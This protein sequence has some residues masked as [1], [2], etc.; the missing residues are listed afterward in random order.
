VFL[1]KIILLIFKKLIMKR[2]L[3]LSLILAFVMSGYA[4]KGSLIPK[5]L[6]NVSKQAV[7]EPRIH[8]LGALENT[9]NPTVNNSAAAKSQEQ[10]GTTWY[11]L[12]S[13]QAVGNRL[14]LFNDG[15]LGAVWMMGFAG[16]EPWSDRGTGYN[17]FD[18]AAWG[19]DP[20]SRI[21]NVKTG[22][23][24]IAPYGENG[25]I[26]V[27][28]TGAA[29][30]LFFNKRDNKGTG[31]WE[32]FFLA[33]PDA[34]NVLVW[35]RMITSGVNNEV[36]QIICPGGNAVPYQGQTPALLYSRSEDG[37]ATWTPLHEVLPGTGPDFYLGINADEYVWAN[38]VGDIIAFLVT[39][40]GHDWFAMKSLDGGSTWEKIMI[41]EHPYPFFDANT[42]LTTDTLW[43]PD[44][45]GDIA[46]DS[47]GKI[48][49]VC[50]LTRIAR[51]ETTPA[52][53]VNYW[54]YTDGVAYWNEDMDPF[55]YPTEPHDALDAWDVLTED[56]N[57]IGWMQDT[58]G[59]GEIEL[60]DGIM[61]YRSLSLTT[62]TNIAIAPDNSIYVVWSGTSEGYIY[63]SNEYNN[64][65]IWM[66]TNH[67]G[68]WG[69]F[70][71]LNTDL[72]QIFDE[73]IYPVLSKNIDDKVHLIYNVDE[74][75]GL[76]LD[77]DHPF[78]ENRMLYY[79]EFL[80]GIENNESNSSGLEVKQNFPNPASSISYI[81]VNT[82][83]STNLNLKIT[84][85]TGQVVY[86]IN[87]G[88]VNEGNHLLK[89]DVTNLSTGVYY[90]TVTAGESS[91][92]KKMIV[93]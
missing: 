93:E 83:E 59:S 66:R 61:S 3:L 26:V 71:D 13:N 4:Q 6:R 18:G 40:Y 48:H 81:S 60:A 23:P 72:I 27:A 10:I 52:G 12:Q 43:A 37:G 82:N 38:P 58:D 32:S 19:D 68:E 9:F 39:D 55:T 53:S 49:A 67:F 85:I 45:A 64:K 46:L 29:Q 65:H 30:G 17:Y 7:V 73:C 21:E 1:K 34:S 86:E 41:W 47:E 69:P 42:T 57:L 75:P 24:S 28:H 62:M 44:G 25:E 80:T 89:F 90:Y 78:Q 2:L 76:G 84:T 50:G 16:A 88:K 51:D 35:P 74:T 92:T 63:G 54:P 8:D 56:V 36:I 87:K 5:N 33:G 77:D 11:D 91:V 31:T 15:T 14:I 79:T 70:V 22:W 20:T